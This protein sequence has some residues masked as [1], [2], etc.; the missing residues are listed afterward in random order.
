MDNIALNLV[1][2]ILHIA[3]DEPNVENIH[4]MVDQLALGRRHATF[5]NSTPNH[6]ITPAVQAPSCLDN[7]TDRDKK[8]N[9]TPSITPI[10]ATK[11]PDSREVAHGNLAQENPVKSRGMFHEFAQEIGSL[12]DAPLASTST[13]NNDKPSTDD[14]SSP[15]FGLQRAPSSAHLTTQVH[16]A[17]PLKNITTIHNEQQ[18]SEKLVADVAKQAT[19][20]YVFNMKEA[21]T[22]S[23]PDERKEATSSRAQTG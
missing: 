3:T 9:T 8:C 22:T 7:R 20:E 5:T 12:F 15:N 14:I 6:G 16:T 1:S 19:Q 11:E 21:T 10:D 4:S 13:N 2:S 23:T 17:K 18:K